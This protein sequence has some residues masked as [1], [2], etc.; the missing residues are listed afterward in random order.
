MSASSLARGQSL[1]RVVV[2]LLNERITATGVTL[3]DLSRTT[4]IPAATLRR[5]LAGHTDLGVA[6]LHFLAVALG[7]TGAD[8]CR[9]AQTEVDG[10]TGTEIPPAGQWWTHEERDDTSET[11]WR[12]RELPTGSGRPQIRITEEETWQGHRYVLIDLPQLE[13]MDLGDLR[14]LRACLDRAILLVERIEGNQP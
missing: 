11:T 3:P 13:N 14:G 12:T 2:R 4:G 8:L 5:E 10:P 1:S 7:T 6:T 9:T